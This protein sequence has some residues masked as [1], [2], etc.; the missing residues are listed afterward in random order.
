MTFQVHT[1]SRLAPLFAH[2]VDGL[3]G[4]PLP[5][6]EPEILVVQSQGMRRW[7]TLGLAD[8]FGCAGSVELPFPTTFIRDL[9]Q[10]LFP[11][12]AVRPGADPFARE[13][14]TWRL[15]RLLR[16]L[17]SEPAYRALQAY[18]GVADERAR[19][20]LAAQIAARFDDYQLYRADLLQQWEDGVEI[21]NTPHAAWQAALWRTL[22]RETDVPGHHLAARLRRIIDTLRVEEPASLPARVTVFGVSALPPMFIELLA[23][24][25]RHRPVSVYTASLDARARHPI[26]QALGMQGR[27]FIEL[28]ASHGAAVATH[29]PAAPARRTLLAVLQHEMA[30]GDAGDT[31][32]A[33]DPADPSL[34]IH[35]AHGQVRQLEI[36]RDQ[37]LA[38]LADD[39]ALRP[40]DL[41]LLVPD[42]TD[43]APL[44]DAVFGVP[45]GDG[46]R[47]P[48]RIA[49]RPTRR[50]QPAADVFGRLLA[51]DGGRLARSEVFTALSAPMARQAA[52]L[53]ETEL[54]TLETLTHRA[55][56]RWGYDADTRTALGLPWYEDASWRAGLDRLLLGVA[57]GPTDDPV[58]GVLPESG[59]TAGD[60]ESFA[61]LADWIDTLAA[62]LADWRT[63]RTLSAW[64]ASLVEAAERLLRA[65]T[66][67]EHRSF[68]SLVST[69]QRLRTMADVAR[70]DGTVSFGVVRDWIDGQ[71]D[72]D[73]LGAGFL[74]GGMTVAALKP[75]RSLPFRVIAVAGLDDGVFPRRDRRAAF[76]LLEQERRPGDRDLRTDDRQLFLDLL[77]AAQERLILT[78]GGRTVRDN[79]PCAPSVVL[80]ELLDHL[81]RRS[82]G[83][84]RRQLVVTHPLQ[85]FSPAYFDTS[86][87]PRLFTYSESRARAARARAGRVAHDLP[88]VTAPVAVPGPTALHELSLRDLV[89]GWENPSRFFCR[90]TLGLY[91][92][93][94]PLHVPDDEPIDLDAMMQGGVRA[95]MLAAMLDGSTDVRRQQL[96][97]RLR[98]RLISGGD[99]PLGALGDAW[100]TRLRAEVENVLVEVGGGSP[101]SVPV[102]I[103]G[104][105]WRLTGRFDQIRGDTRFVVRAGN[106][107]AGHRIRAWIEHVVMCAARELGTG[108]LPGTTRILGKSSGSKSAVDRQIGVV[109]NA[110]AVLDALVRTVLRARAE[111]LPFFPQA[112]WAWFEAGLPAKSSRSAPKDPRRQALA[113][114]HADSR[115]GLPGDAHDP[116][117]ALCF[118]GADPMT[119]RWD[120]FESLARQLFGAWPAEERP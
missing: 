108:E 103:D 8:A 112:G 85:P 69:L 45:G 6:H 40:H 26:A 19:F 94:E 52:G 78:Y 61:R 101:V 87:D 46:A 64:S 83:E 4:A 35:D 23:A 7:V 32:L 72:D 77:L 29:E 55:F 12:S 44:V 18:L 33:L 115:F 120:E 62:V 116:Y 20:G 37:L 79:A 24:L 3:R 98:T 36:L 109:A 27:E 41:L 2:L 113:A 28:L 68:E 67:A 13:P 91:L 57:V 9:E 25:A 90:H 75:M 89:D 111:P 47:I 65:D 86:D 99:L 31:P 10:R 76:D 43:W 71:L 92:R 80:D 97:Q 14:M 106:V 82:A 95:R 59:D 5:P 104:N 93:E 17:P 66:A 56:V 53:S 81:D 54:E 84:A 15:D 96:Q 117:V 38:A 60:P 63:P 21:P 1:A 34:R 16:A 114:Y 102:R 39:P 119:E 22:R 48:Y 105:G 74:E 100:Y 73:G 50:A 118:R 11:E 110:P 51:L 88:F 49:D 30:G 70:Y 42:A 58:L 107:R